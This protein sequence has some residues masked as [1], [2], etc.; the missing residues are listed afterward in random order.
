VSYWTGAI[1][2][3][4]VFCKLFAQAYIGNECV[5]SNYVPEPPYRFAM[6][7]AAALMLGW[8]LLLIWADRD[9]V[10]RRGVLMLTL[11][12]ILGLIASAVLAV[13]IGNISFSTSVPT[14]I[15]LISLFT[16]FGISYVLS[17][18]R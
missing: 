11:V 14:F 6:A 17:R 5:L 18:S 7:V 3:G 12:V 4:I 1:V 8:T 16:L 13:S 15:V 10:A 9:P 2:D